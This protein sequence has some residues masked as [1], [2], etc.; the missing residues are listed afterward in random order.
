MVT[1]PGE[2]Y[3][4]HAATTTLR[5][6]AIEA[7]ERC[8]ADGHGNASGTHRAARRAKNTLEEAR[9][10][11]AQMIGAD[12]PHDVVF[13]SG[14]TESDNLAV[15]GSALASDNRS[16]VVSSVEHKAVLKSA[17]SLGRFGYSARV[18]P[19]DR[20]G[21]IQPE[22]VA[23]LVDADTAV[24]SVMSANN[25]TGTVEPIEGIVDGVRSQSATAVIHTDAVQHFVA[26]PPNL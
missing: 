19:S 14:G 12:S 11:A 18:V 7:L 21:V 10:H 16:I 26:K 23:E 15:V 8:L 25:E 4:D 2:I 17:T 24:V 1:R 5:P 20:N 9:E 3:L 13:T 6:V 22:A